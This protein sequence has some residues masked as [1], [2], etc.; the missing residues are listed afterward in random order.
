MASMKAAVVRAKDEVHVEDVDID[1]P[2]P[3]EV[4]IRTVAAGVCKSDLSLVK[5]LLPPPPPIVLG[6]E[7]AGVV[8]RVGSEVTYVKPGDH[9]VTCL[10][11]F[12]GQCEYCLTGHA[13][14]CD[15]KAMPLRRSPDCPR[16]TQHGEAL[17]QM[18]GLASFAERLLVHQNSVVKIP[19]GMPLQEAS[20]LGCGVTTGLGAVLHTAK[21][22]VGATVAVIGCGGVGLSAIQGARISGAVR[23]IGID[24][25]P[26]RLELARQLGATDTVNA[27]TEDIVEAVR[28]LTAGGVE[29]SFEV[30]GGSATAEQAFAM[31]RP[32]GTATVVG[33]TFGDTAIRV[34]G[35]LLRAERKLQ[36]SLMGSASFRVMIPRY[37]ELYLQGR[38]KLDEVVSAHYPLE[39]IGDALTAAVRGEGARSIVVFDGA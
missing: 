5:G 16:L 18:V 30:V 27:T 39:K 31:L 17:P 10:S 20:L 21:V 11:L 15:R 14:L 9:V 33:L 35:A 8:E 32:G 23:I 26:A 29:Y 12:C 1:E 13:A 28:E 7:S 34:P 22:P 4:L 19:D 25:D 6:H 24:M 2:A 3:D 38:L 36:G 37:V